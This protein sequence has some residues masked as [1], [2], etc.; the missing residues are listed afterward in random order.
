MCA[1][2]FNNFDL[3]DERA[4]KNKEYF[5][6]KILKAGFRF[7]ENKI[8][9]LSQRGKAVKI[10][11]EILCHITRAVCTKYHM[12]DKLLYYPDAFL[13]LRLI[14]VSLRGDHNQNETRRNVFP[15]CFAAS[16]RVLRVS[17]FVLQVNIADVTTRKQ[18]W[19]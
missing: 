1:L 4:L 6:I 7:S 5:D 15:I 10:L 11:T 12:D 3:K 18:F 17:K 16:L 8:P 9:I 19:S 2:L 13:Q 14:V